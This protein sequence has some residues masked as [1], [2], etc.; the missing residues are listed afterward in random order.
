MGKQCRQVS[1]IGPQEP[2]AMSLERSEAAWDPQDAPGWFFSA[3]EVGDIMG[4]SSGNV[5][6]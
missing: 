5:M 1:T 6:G 2:L 4:F 3:T